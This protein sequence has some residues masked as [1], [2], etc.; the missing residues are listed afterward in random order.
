M[1]A[2]QPGTA[3]VVAAAFAV[4]FAG[5]TWACGDKLVALGGGV[6]FQRVMVSRNPSHIVILLEPATGLNAANDRFNFAAS[7]LLAG[8]EVFIV[9]NA[10]DLKAQRDAPAPDLIMV[11]A[12]RAKQIRLQPVAGGEGPL[13][14]PVGYSAERGE[15]EVTERNAGCVLVSAGRKS[16]QLLKAVEL[17]LKHRSRGVPLPCDKIGDSRK[18]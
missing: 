3:A 11:D 9:K 15:L 17:A 14:M 16:T 13:V 10:D 2:R 1:R 12:A 4:S 5:T 8:H 7:L 18:T 6:G